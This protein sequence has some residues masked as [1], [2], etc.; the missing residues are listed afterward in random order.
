MKSLRERF[1]RLR[2]KAPASKGSVNPIPRPRYERDRATRFNKVFCIG[3]NK[4]GTTTLL[5]VLRYYRFRL[6]QQE[7]QQKLLVESTFRTD[8]AALREMVE[9]Y[10]AFQDLPFSQGLTYVACDAL[11]PDSKFIL[12][13]RDPDNW[14]ESAYESQKAQFGFSDDD[15]LGEDYFRNKNLYL[16]EGYVHRVAERILTVADG[17]RARPDW[18]RL[19]DPAH[20]KKLYEER[21]AGILTYFADRPD[22]LLVLDV[23]QERDTARLCRFLGIPEELAIDFPHRNRRPVD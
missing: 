3:F 2:R 17:R 9:Q 7:A 14:F 20:Y 1:A 12:S 23:T 6:P 13:V 16:Y 5:E 15:E 4:T 11:F 21:N 19:Y 8:Y 10:D 22:K 18:S